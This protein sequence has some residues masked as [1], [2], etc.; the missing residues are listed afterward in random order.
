MGSEMCIRDRVHPDL[1]KA[2]AQPLRELSDEEIID[3]IRPL[4][5]TDESAEMAAKVSMDEFRAVLKKAR[6][7]D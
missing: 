7:N 4:Y 3:A 1:A 2:V 6:G 5:G